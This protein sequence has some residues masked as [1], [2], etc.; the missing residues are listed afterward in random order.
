MHSGDHLIKDS[1]KL[2]KKKSDGHVNRSQKPIVQQNCRELH[3]FPAVYNDYN[4][5]PPWTL[6]KRMGL[7]HDLKLKNVV[8]A[9]SVDIPKKI[10]KKCKGRNTH[11]TISYGTNGWA[12]WA[13]H[14]DDESL[15]RYLDCKLNLF[16]LL[17]V[18]NSGRIKYEN[19]SGLHH[20]LVNAL[21]QHS[22]LFPPCEQTYALHEL[23]H[24]CDQIPKVGPPR[25]N[26]CYMFER[27]NLTMKRFIR[28]KCHSLPSI[29]KSYAVSNFS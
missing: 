24:V 17:S 1:L 18:L 3:L 22:M 2:F 10:F 14:T 5:P 6:S 13:L 4:K 11:E 25:F 15:R 9:F 19:V 12:A 8:G 7:L 21:V 26:N 20:Q 27:L 23:I 16:D 28:N 29:M